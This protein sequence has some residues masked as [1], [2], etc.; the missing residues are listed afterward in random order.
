[1]RELPKGDGESKGAPAKAEDKMQGPMSSKRSGVRADMRKTRKKKVKPKAKK[2]KKQRMIGNHA[3]LNDAERKE[4]LKQR[5]LVK[6]PMHSDLKREID[7]DPWCALDND[8]IW[9]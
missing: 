3:V 8:A 5:Y 6:P 1:M 2:P 7:E 9:S 4:M